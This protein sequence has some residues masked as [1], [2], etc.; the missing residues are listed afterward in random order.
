MISDYCGALGV[1]EDFNMVQERGFISIDLQVDSE[2]VA[3]Y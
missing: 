1:Y 3:R 2:V